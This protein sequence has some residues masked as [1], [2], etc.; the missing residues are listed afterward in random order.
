[1][2]QWRD[3]KAP[4]IPD[5]TPLKRVCC[6]TESEDDV[7]EDR[8]REIKIEKIGKLRDAGH[9]PYPER[10]ER[11]HTLAEAS[12]LEEGA[13]GVRICG[14]IVSRRDFGKLTFFDLQDLHGRMQCSVQKDDLG[15][16]SF[17]EFNK[18][19]D[20]GDFVGVEGEV[21]KT[22]IGQ[23]TVRA[24]QWTFL[25]KML[26]PMPEKFHAISDRE[27]RYRRRYLDLISDE[28]SRNRFRLRRD[29]IRALRDGLDEASFDE[30]ETPVLQTKPSGAL[31]TPFETHHAALDIPV[32]MR[33]AP[34]TYLKRCIVAGFDRVYEFARVFRNEGMDPSHL[35]DFT[36]LEYYA[37][38]WNYIDNMD[39]TENLLRSAIEKCTGSLVVPHTA[40]DIDFGG[41]WPR[42]SMTDLVQEHAGINLSECPDADSIRAAIAG[43]GISLD[44]VDHLGRGA[45]IDQ[46][47][48]K[49]VR[50]HLKQ[51]TFVV[52]HPVDL[53][54]LA[55]SNDDDPTI[56]DRFQLVIHGWEVINAY[57]ELVDP[58]DQRG[59]L[60]EQAKLHA[61]G[62]DEAMVM[63]EDYLMAME[64]GMP[65]ISGWGMGIDRMVAL[66]CG[67]E[68]L[69]DVV[70]FPLLKPEEGNAV[71]EALFNEGEEAPAIEGADA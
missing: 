6:K 53:S 5:F 25:G 33:I 7:A 22:R 32:Y 31:A 35:Q 41:E 13:T 39:F 63:E 64:H 62:D 50:P 46:L 12:G 36:M 18:L 26:R 60:E 30:V 54:P 19:V 37:A 66:L 20:I 44:D 11:S 24:S 48:K 52:Q 21:Y 34:E 67:A 49:T 28:E 4:G 56:T 68:N 61:D 9:H 27:I 17:K 15:A 10:W 45:L 1:M 40:G 42:K 58:I 65:P 29:F 14:R 51:P 55:R 59:R 38:Y 8:I 71:E 43:R 47:Y 16:D 23:L 69:R 3:L 70:L 57:S 2:E